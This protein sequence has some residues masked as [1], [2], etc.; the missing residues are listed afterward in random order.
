MYSHSCDLV[1][2]Q[3]TEA[4]VQFAHAREFVL[5]LL[6]REITANEFNPG[7]AWTERRSGSRSGLYQIRT[8]SSCPVFLHP[9]GVAVLGCHSP[10][11]SRSRWSRE[12]P[13]PEAARDEERSSLGERLELASCPKCGRRKIRKRKGH[14]RCPRCGNLTGDR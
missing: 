4:A 11:P 14:R 13:I 8:D 6:F 2:H 9:T 7:A 5:S 10:A 1:S 3:P 12:R